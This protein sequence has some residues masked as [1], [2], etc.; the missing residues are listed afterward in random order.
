MLTAGYF[1]RLP[2]I[3]YITAEDVENPNSLEKK[4][5]GGGGKPNT[6]ITV[7][8]A[9]EQSVIIITF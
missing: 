1:P 3:I 2:A 9:S 8:L 4:G 5:G 6:F 7:N